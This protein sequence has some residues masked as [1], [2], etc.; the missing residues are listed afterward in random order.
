MPEKNN[1]K[2]NFK[3]STPLKRAYI[4]VSGPLIY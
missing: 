3:S 2:P 4:G 1:Q